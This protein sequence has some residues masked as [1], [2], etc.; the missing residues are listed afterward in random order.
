MQK[1][2]T[3]A[4]KDVNDAAQMSNQ[5]R[6][7][8]QYHIRARSASEDGTQKSRETSFEKKLFYGVLTPGSHVLKSS[9]TTPTTKEPVKAIVTVGNS[10]MAKFAT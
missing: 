3:K 2:M 6:S 10:D 1:G 4:I 5:D 7:A 8:D 9:P